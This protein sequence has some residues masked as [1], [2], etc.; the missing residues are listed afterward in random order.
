MNRRW[1]GYRLL[2]SFS[3]RSTRAS[4]GLDGGRA[5]RAHRARRAPRP[6][7]DALGETRQ[8]IKAAEMLELVVT[9]GADVVLTGTGSALLRG[10]VKARKKLL[11]VPT[12][13]L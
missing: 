6:T 5:G 4:P 13:K 11:K 2:P 12:P 8:V 1:L 7:S 3:A 10:R 9:P